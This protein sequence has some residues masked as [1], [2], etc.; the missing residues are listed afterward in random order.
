MFV[1]IGNVTLGIAGGMV[2]SSAKYGLGSSRAIGVL[3]GEEFLRCSRN[4]QFVEYT[5]VS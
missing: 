3:L 5:F 4:Y 2:A 1:S